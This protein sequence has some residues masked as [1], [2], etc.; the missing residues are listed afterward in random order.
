MNTFHLFEHVERLYQARLEAYGKCRGDIQEHH[1]IEQ[2]VLAG[3][4]GYRQVLELVQNGADAILEAHEAGNAPSEGNRVQVIL[5]TDRLYVANSGAP[6]TEEGLDALLHSHSSPKRGNQIGRFGLGFKSLLK[7]GGRI[8]VFTKDAGAIRFDPERCRRVLQEKFGVRNAPGLRLAWSLDETECVA[9]A[10]LGA[11]AW[12]ETIVRVDIRTADFVEHLRSEIR[13]FPSE[14]LLFLPVSVTLQLDDGVEP[15]RELRVETPSA[16]ERELFMG[17][18]LSRWRVVSRE[19]AITDERARA[20][21]THIHARDSVPLAWAMPL[22]GER[23]EAGRFWAFFPTH[24]LTYVPGILNA[25]WKVNDDRNAIIGGEWNRLLMREAAKLIAETLPQLCTDAD[26]AQALDAFP[27]QLE[28]KDEDAAPLVEALWTAIENAAVAPDATGTLR[29][30]REL[31]LHPRENPDVARQWQALAGGDELAQMVHPLCLQRQRSSRLNALAERLKPQGTETPTCPNLRRREADTWFAAVASSDTERALQVLKLAEAYAGDCTPSD[32]SAVRQSIAIIPSNEGQL[33]NANQAVF[34]PEGTEVPDGRHPVTHQLCEDVEAKR[35]L[36]DVMKV[37][38]LDDDVWESVLREALKGIPTYPAEARDVGWRTFWKKLRVAPIAVRQQFIAQNAHDIRVKRRDSEWVSPDEALLPGTLVSPNDNSASQ[39]VLVDLS[40]HEGDEALLTALG[41]SDFPDGVVSVREH[42]SLS[43]W[44]SHWKNQCQSVKRARWRYLKP[45]ADITLPKCWSFLT[46]LEGAANVRL[47]N[48]LLISVGLG[49]FAGKIRFGHTTSS[50]YPDI[51][52]PHPL[53]WFLLKHGT[54]QVGDEA[55]RL[56]AVGN[57]YREPALARLPNWGQLQPALEKL[58]GAMP[59]VS[60]TPAEICALWLALIKTLA[61]PSALADDS[62]RDLWA[63]AARNEVVPESLLTEGGEV[64]L[65]QVLV[66]G[67]PDLAQRARKAGHLAVTL[68]DH[69]FK[70]WLERGAR[71]LA[72]LMKPEWT[73]QTGPADLLKGAI[74]ELVEVLRDEVR[75]GARCQPV[76]GLKLVVAGNADFVPCLMW[77]NALLLDAT[78]LASL[79]RAE[80]LQRLLAEVAAAG[81][82]K[83]EAAE[84]LRILGDAQVDALRA[85]VAQGSTLA[86]RLLLAV[87]KHEEPLKQALGNLAGMDFI[88]QCTPIQLAGLALAQLGPAI[89][90]TLKDTLEAEG[91]KPPTRWNTAEARGFV[92]SIGF[93]EEFAA[94]PEVRRESEEFIS[95]PIDLPPRHDFQEEVYEGIRALVASGTTRRRAV[96]SLPTGGGKTRV[97]VE[98]AVLLVL[99]PESDRRSVIWVAQTDELCEQ[100]VQAFRQVWLNLG[101]QRTDLRIVRMWGGNPNPAI[102]EPDKPVVVVASIQ[103]LNS[104]M[105]TDELAWLQNPGLVVVDECHH[106][107]TPSYTNLL[108]WLDAEAPR[109]GAPPKEEPPILGL[110]ATPFRTDDEES[111]RLARR[112]DNRW[113]PSN[114]ENLH[115]RLRRQGVLAEVD[116]EALDSGVGLSQEETERLS[117]LPEPWEGI[118]FENLLEAI[119]QRLAGSRQRNERLV[120]RIKAA[121]ERSILFFAN[122][123]LHAEEMSARLNLQNISA[124]AVSGA[125]PRGA[126][127]YFLE[128][129]QQG[130]IRVLCNHSV[131]STGF[132]APKTDMVL[133]SRAV[134]SPVRYMQMVGRGLRGEKN[135][136]T[137]RCRIITV[138]DNL[139]RFQDRHPF[140]FCAKYF[141]EASATR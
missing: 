105:G 25:P 2:R 88:Q 72:E 120:E 102:Q 39:D 4:Y 36:A 5:R 83:H 12:A 74:P 40:F 6:L 118:D 134:F 103:T 21:A 1:G 76:A 41:I 57:Q 17:E 64:P 139:G 123:V 37:K 77:E 65:S 131:L 70:L 28:R 115:V 87:G 129:F 99:K 122:S 75:D 50:D 119:N 106:A 44:Q 104:R 81:W 137:A 35:I 112:F 30:A 80:R 84:A 124:A 61:I 107:I 82:L 11:L 130:E 108:R 66:T 69:A 133:I 113:L 93:P 15:L 42:S 53:P 43:D 116:S 67:S 9:D 97:T 49:E 45:L 68:D 59:R 141:S 117:Q 32:W 56:A 90:T 94:S 55:I 8:D 18:E 52:V 10:V 126:R 101:A 58:E 85:T 96:V 47:T 86:E 13:A 111:Q 20:D 14:F 71:N 138:L 100:A 31:W 29:P 114:Q 27:R 135:G 89:L 98:A 33:L 78:Q 26:P 127:R 132:D 109:A 51:D 110:S 38:P 16:N 34:A 3:G 136:G 24:T 140:H 46:E 63:G 7:L 92:A 125:T 79:S 128:R 22:G 19:V 60:A 91:L 73:E 54:V 23:E 95:G 121:G 48:R 62:L